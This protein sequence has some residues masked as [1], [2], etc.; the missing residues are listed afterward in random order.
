VLKGYDP[1]LNLVLDGCTEYLRGMLTNNKKNNNNTH[2]L[3]V[4]WLF[5][6]RDK[7]SDGE[8]AAVV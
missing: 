6:F 2:Y 7:F 1:L 4:D 5:C 3:G 8:T